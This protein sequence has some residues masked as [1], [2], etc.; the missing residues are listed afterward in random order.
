MAIDYQKTKLDALDQQLISL[1]AQDGRM[2]SKEL[3]QKLKVSAPTVKSRM[4]ALVEN[5]ILKV[6]G[7]INPIKTQDIS[8]AVIGI[9]VDDVAKMKTIIDQLMEFSQV[10]S[11]VAVTGQYDIFA[12]VIIT[13]GIE[14]MFDFYVDE[15]SKL[16]GVSHSESFMVT[17]MRRKWTLLPTKLKGWIPT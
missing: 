12:E 15:M 4:K 9:R 10:N 16:D 5:G 2:P 11:V 17:H 8:M 14:W 1:L 13:Q 6:A 3:A 7:L